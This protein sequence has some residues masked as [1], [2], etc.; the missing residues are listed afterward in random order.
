M[1]LLYLNP[2]RGRAEE[3]RVLARAETKAELEAFIERE[4]VESYRDG[5]WFKTFQKGGPL[6]WFNRPDDNPW[7]ECYCDVGTLDD[8]LADTRERWNNMLT[9]IRAV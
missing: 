7:F 5:H 2:M 4:S 1:W 9:D 6:E 3:N 8:W